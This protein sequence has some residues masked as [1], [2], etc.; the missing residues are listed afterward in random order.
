MEIIHKRR[1]A[2]YNRASQG[3]PGYG[4]GLQSTGHT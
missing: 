4:A 3:A 2:G 1:G